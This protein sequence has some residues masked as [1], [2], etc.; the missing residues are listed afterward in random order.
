MDCTMAFRQE[1][2]KMSEDE[3][4]EYKRSLQAELTERIFKLNKLR[5]A[6]WA[7]ISEG[8]FDFKKK[9]HL[10]EV[11][12]KLTL[13]D[14]LTL[15]DQYIL[16]S[17]RRVLIVEYGKRDGSDYSVVLEDDKTFTPSSFRE[18]DS[19][20]EKQWKEYENEMV[21]ELSNQI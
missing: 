20:Q 11:V 6:F 17:K 4:N 21:C 19:F 7:A 15:M 3:F 12:E 10:A 16:G 9:Q 8:H 2:E 1:L 18:I 13:T 5:K 14:L